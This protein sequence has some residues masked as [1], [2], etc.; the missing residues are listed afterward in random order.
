LFSKKFLNGFA[1]IVSKIVLQTTLFK[2]LKFHQEN[3]HFSI[4]HIMALLNGLEQ[5]EV[6]LKMNDIDNI[7]DIYNNRNETEIDDI[8]KILLYLLGV[9]L[10]D[11]SVI[12]KIKTEN[13]SKINNKDYEIIDG[14]DFFFKI[15]I[16]DVDQKFCSN[17]IK[18]DKLENVL[19]ELNYAKICSI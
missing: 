2:Q 5:H 17:I 10:K 12:I 19:K 11:I 6:D 18:I 3:L 16:I 4:S 1:D 14:S 7:L 9:T 13:D 15:K 8:N